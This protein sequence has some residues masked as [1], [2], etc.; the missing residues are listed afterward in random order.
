MVTKEK[1]KDKAERTKLDKKES[2]HK[3]EAA[4]KE[5]RF[6]IPWTVRARYQAGATRRQRQEQYNH[7][8]TVFGVLFGVTLVAGLLFIFINYR[9]AGSTK[10]ASCDDYPQYCVP[11]AGGAQGDENFQK[12]ETAET[13]TLDADSAGVEGVIRGFTSISDANDQNS[14][15]T[16]FI[17]DPNAPFQLMLVA[18]F[19][20]SHCQTYHQ[21]ELSNIIK[22][23]V[24]TGKANLTFLMTTGT[25]GTFSETVSQAAMCAGEQGAF[26]EMS[27]EI[28][29]LGNSMSVQEAFTLSQMR[30]SANA[31]GLNG[32][33]LESCVTSNRYSPIIGSYTPV[34]YS[35]GVTGT[36]TMLF[37]KGST[38]TWT[39]VDRDYGTIQNLIEE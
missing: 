22:D 34:T 21:G 36:P 11:L 1:V 13:R 38:G 30:E 24:L 3:S 6:S 7:Q 29:R 26:W 25:G 8:L 37:R 35:Y 16:P 20:C 15:Y 31:M 19:A 17:G 4:A 2:P 39:K 28:F 10:S 27:D 12:N 33:T 9:G 18:D 14:V 5:P 23:F 32:N